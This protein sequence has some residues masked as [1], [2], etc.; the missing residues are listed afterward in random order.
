MDR[1]SVDL[2]SLQSDEYNHDQPTNL[3]TWLICLLN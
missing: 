1:K 3:K 2:L